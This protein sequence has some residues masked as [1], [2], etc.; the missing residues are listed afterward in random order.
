LSNQTNKKVVNLLVSMERRFILAVQTEL[1][2]GTEFLFNKVK[3]PHGCSSGT[4][5]IR[6]NGSVCSV[7][8]DLF[9]L[10][11]TANR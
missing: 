8:G 3:A 11:K 2:H 5:R 4:Q 6:S 10:I 1:N 7:G 9:N